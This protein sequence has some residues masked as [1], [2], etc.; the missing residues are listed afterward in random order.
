MRVRWTPDAA[1]DLERICDYIAESR[2][3]FARRVA[4]TIIEGI[5][6][7]HSFPNRGRL[8]RADGNYQIR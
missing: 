7:L 6:A 8:G 4:Q 2:P 3:D 1:G 5:A